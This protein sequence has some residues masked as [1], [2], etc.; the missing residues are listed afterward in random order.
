MF[1]IRKP[2]AEKILTESLSDACALLLDE[3]S[4]GDRAPPIWLAKHMKDRII[5]FSPWISSLGCMRV[6]HTAKTDDRF[7]NASFHH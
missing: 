7:P 5:F 1:T 3:D 2:K 6:M 4:S